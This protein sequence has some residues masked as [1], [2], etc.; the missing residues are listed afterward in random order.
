MTIQCQ[1]CGLPTMLHSNMILPR[2]ANPD[3]SLND[4][5]AIALA[6]ACCK[7]LHLYSLR[8][9]VGRTYSEE[10]M[11]DDRPDEETVHV[12]TLQCEEKDC[13][14]RLPL[15]AVWSVASTF[16]GRRADTLTWQWEHLLCPEGTC[17]PETRRV[18]VACILGTC[19]RRQYG[20]A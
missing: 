4:F 14:S 3:E 17:N 7:N 5:S 16:G 1:D 2:F 15:F 19:C 9:I 18:G 6:C 13:E 11:V 8:R 10:V 12:H 20:H